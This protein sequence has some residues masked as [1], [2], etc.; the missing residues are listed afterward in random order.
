[1]QAGRT[2]QAVRPSSGREAATASALARYIRIL[3]LEA[4]ALQAL[5]VVDVGSI[6]VLEAHGINEQG[7]LMFVE[8]LVELVGPG[9][10]KEI[11]GEPRT[12]PSDDPQA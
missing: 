7:N 10:E 4:G 5:H 8:D 9:V 12:P 2:K 6:E 3:E 11:V 1:V